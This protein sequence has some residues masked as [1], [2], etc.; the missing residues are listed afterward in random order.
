MAAKWQTVLL[1]VA[2]LICSVGGMLFCYFLFRLWL[3]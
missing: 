3:G 1:V 2:A